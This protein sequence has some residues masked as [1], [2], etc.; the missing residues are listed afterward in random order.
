MALVRCRTLGGDR[1][2]SRSARARDATGERNRGEVRSGIRSKRRSE[3]PRGRG[4]DGSHILPFH[5]G[6]ACRPEIRGNGEGRAF[7]PLY[8][9]D[10]LEVALG[11]AT[12]IEEMLSFDGASAKAA[13]APKVTGCLDQCER[14]NGFCIV[15][16]SF[17]AALCRLQAESATQEFLCGFRYELAIIGCALRFNQCVNLCMPA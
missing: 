8:T 16:A 4:R 15:D 3:N 9:G 6:H 10:D 13:I 5:H 1:S 2:A 7:L 11:M 12:S 14:Q 17:T